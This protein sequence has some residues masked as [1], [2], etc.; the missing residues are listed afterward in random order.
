MSTSLGKV[1]PHAIFLSALEIDY[2]VEVQ[3]KR[4]VMP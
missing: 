1:R 2:L 4:V 3:Q